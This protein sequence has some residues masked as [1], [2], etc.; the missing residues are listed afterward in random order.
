M[1]FPIFKTKVDNS[2]KFDLSDLKQREEYFQLKCGEDI[3]KVKNY[4]DSGKTFIAYLLGKKNSGKGTYSKMF[5]EVIGPDKIA[6][7]SIGDMVRKI[8]EEMQDE[9]RK[10]ELVE[11]L[12][13]NYRGFISLDEIIKSLEDRDIKSL[14]PDELILTLIKREISANKG[15]AIFIDGFPRSMDQVSFSLFFRDLVDYREDP[16]IFVLIDVPNAVIDERIKW[17]RICPKCQMSRSL[18]LLPTS[19]VG[20][21]KEK[22]EFFLECDDPNC[23]GEKMVNKEG[24]ELGIEPI[25]E[26]IETDAKILEKAYSLHG[27]P[28]VLLRNAVPADVANENFNDYEITPGY[29]YTWNEEEQKVETEEKPWTIKDDEGTESVSLMAAPVVIA[30]IKQLASILKL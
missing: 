23:T 30:F 7:V 13:K 26:R 25:R 14:L 29:Y 12:E 21:D 8:N 16:D 18:K 1:D 22:G 19:K 28:K 24:D 20:Y 5:A 2:P 17:R 4:L 9:G 15:K 6:H 27:V 3:Q 10:K 11:F